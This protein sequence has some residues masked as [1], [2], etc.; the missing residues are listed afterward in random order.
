MTRPFRPDDLHDLRSVTDVAVHP[1]TERV[2]YEV[3]WPDRDRD[4][5]RSQLW[6]HAPGEHRPLTVAHAASRPRISPDGRRMALLVTFEAGD[7]PQVGLLS[8]TGGE[9]QVVTDLPDGVTDL[10]WC[11]DSDALVVEAPTRPQDQVGVPDDELARRPRIITEQGARF[12]GRG[13]VHD[14]RKQLHLV[15]LGTG[16]ERAE[17]RQLTRFPGDA[18]SPAV[19]GSATVV[20]AAVAGPD[21]DL[22][23]VVDLWTLQLA[24]G[25]GTEPQ[26]LT[27][28][29]GEWVDACWLPDG[30]LLARGAE[31]VGVRFARAHV[32]DPAGGA[33]QRVGDRD[34]NTVVLGASLRPVVLDD[35][36]IVPA[37][38]R[39]AVH[40]DRLSL[41]DGRS[42]PAV[43]GPVA[44]TCAAA[45]PSGRRLVAGIVTETRPAGLFEVSGNTPRR[46]SDHDERFTRSV[47]VA[48]V[49]EVEAV[50]ADGSVVPGFVVT[51]PPGA[52]GEGGRRP[53]LVFVH[54][55][56]MGQ[57]G[58]TLF[59][60]FQV[61]A[62]GG[63]V[64]IGGNP[65][66]SDGYGEEWA[67]G[68]IGD[69]GGPDWQ[70]VQ[71]L[72]DVLAARD[73]VDPDRIGIAGG[74]Y[75]GFMA[76]WAIGHTDRYGAA[77]VERAVTNWETMTTTSD[78]GG[79]FV[80]PYLEA[81]VDTDV[82]ALRR[83]S[84]VAYA[85]DVRTPTLIV[86]SEED[87]RCP[88]EQ[89]EQLFGILRRRRVDVTLV[90][91]PGEDHELSRRGRPSHRVERFALIHRFLAER[92][93]GAPVDEATEEP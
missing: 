73:D 31:E 3:A 58:P 84:P 45:D 66:G 54:G 26:R 2:V 42:Q 80:E 23:G 20:F 47:D 8:L 4:A 87:W 16:D 81:D 57:Y 46:L 82:D 24:D 89:A 19:S 5:N 86:H 35:A 59:D 76:A 75:G 36:V 17:V 64:V 9:L 43:S 67:R 44:V 56:P 29:R 38:R 79:W 34:V 50:S 62:A 14:R 77:V 88:I 71:A 21:G 25:A 48:P 1:D 7:K 10:A 22:T 72:T 37:V 6:L 28:G 15:T 61:A 60:E 65:R 41:R 78:I 40:L 74:S 68:L 63:Y 92:L 55:G 52:P 83:Q 85:T 51:P 33:P 70:D 11:P 27:D 39:G 49:T 90:R 18:T 69:L 32:I 13:W 93:G 53:G 12:N 30:R 91:F